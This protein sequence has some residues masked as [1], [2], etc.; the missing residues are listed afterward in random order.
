MIISGNGGSNEDYH[1]NLV[2]ALYEIVDKK[3]ET[4]LI[5]S[6]IYVCSS[7]T[8]RLKKNPLITVVHRTNPEFSNYS[9]ETMSPEFKRSL[10]SI[11]GEI[12]LGVTHLPLFDPAL[13]RNI[14]GQSLG[15]GLGI[16]SLNRFIT[17]NSPKSV[18]YSRISKEVIKI[19]GLACGLSHCSDGNCILTYHR[20][21]ED[22]DLNK[23]ICSS[24]KDNL[25]DEFNSLFGDE[26]YDE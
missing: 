23:T 6:L 14:F 11:G 17:E 12:I 24:C 3:E 9:I 15:M 20:T 19:L 18:Y 10:E 22:L 16:F 21:M 1:P 4:S 26:D 25:V 5:N 2:L 8:P 7:L 13:G